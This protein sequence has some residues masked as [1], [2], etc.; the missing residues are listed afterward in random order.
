MLIA[1]L[2]PVHLEAEMEEMISH[3]LIGGVRY[4][5]GGHSAYS[6]QETLEKILSLT[7]QYDKKF[8]LDIK[9]YQ[10]RIDRWTLGDLGKVVLNHKVEVDLPARIYFRGDD[11]SNIKVINGNTIYVD[12][13]PKYSVGEGQAINIHGDNLKIDGYL[14]DDDYKYLDPACK[15]GVTN[16][17]L[18]FVEQITNIVEVEDVLDNNGLIAPTELV[19]KIESP[20]GLDFVQGVSP[21]FLAVYR[22]MAARDDWFINTTPKSQILLNLQ[23][24]IRLD[25]NAILASH[26]FGDLEKAGM[27]TMADLSDLYLMRTFGY[28]NFMLS[29]GISRRHFRKAMEAW[30]EFQKTIPVEEFE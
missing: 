8:W 11:Y 5:I 26:I 25:P 2:P 7:T 10:L 20:N 15:L 1:T 19:L 28:K 13:L 4:N 14:T 18:S 24:L 3:P 16:Y 21:E 23:E 6:P 27:V 9:G 12:P 29:D 30:Q 17:M 22:L